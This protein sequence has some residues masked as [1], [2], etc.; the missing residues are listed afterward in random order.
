MLLWVN[1][2]WYEEVTN[3]Y[4]EPLPNNFAC[5]GGYK[6]EVDIILGIQQ[7]P[8]NET[9]RLKEVWRIVTDY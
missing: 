5:Y 6:F 3:W 1:T 8:R 9:I 4:V 2:T 7:G